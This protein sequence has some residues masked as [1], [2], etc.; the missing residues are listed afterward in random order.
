MFSRYFIA[1]PI[2]ASVCAAFIVIAGGAA[3]FN[4][5]Q[6]QWPNIQPREISVTTFYPGANAETLAN[7]V[8]APLEQQIGNVLGLMYTQSTSSGNGQL[9]IRATFDVNADIDVALLEV[10]SRAQKTLPR[11]PEEVRRQ[12]LSISKSAS[13]SLLIATLSSPDRRFDLASLNNYARLNI[14]D[15]LNRLPGVATVGLFTLRYYSLRIWLQP[16]KLARLGLSPLDVL[17]A[18]REQN[19]QYTAGR[20]G[21]EPLNEPVDFTFTVNVPG[22]MSTPE[23][24]E[25]IVLRTASSGAIVRLK[26]VARVELGSNRY[27]TTSKLNGEPALPLNITV[28]SGANAI[29]TAKIVRARL[30]ELSKTFPEGL[31]YSVNYDSTVHIR[32]AI[33]EVTLTLFEA[34]AL[35]F[36][37][38]FLF[39]G[40]WR[41]TLIP[42]LAVPVSI[43]GAFAV[44]YQMDF[45]I[46]IVTLFG[47]VFAIGIVV[48]DAIVVMENVQRIMQ[49]QGVDAR[50]ATEQTMREVTRPV[51]A[52]VLVLVAVFMP[53]AFMSG[54][55]GTIYRQF[56]VTIAGSVAISGIVALTLTPALCA[57][58]LR[59]SDAQRSGIAARFH[60]GFI[61]LTHGYARVVEFFVRQRLLSGFVFIAVLGAIGVFAYRIPVSLVP[62]E[63]RGLVYA[64][65][66]LP[67]AASMSRSQA[68]VDDLAAEL[69]KHPAV[70]DVIAFAGIDGISNSFLPGG[71]NMWIMLKPWNERRGK[72]MAPADVMESIEAFGRTGIHDAQVVAFEPSPIAGGSNTGNVDGFIQSRG[73]SDPKTL[74]KA[75]QA[76]VKA[77]KERKELVGVGTSY[78]ANVPQIRIDVDRDKAKS[79]GIDIGDLFTTL[80]SNFG[81]YYINDFMYAGRVWEVQMQ[82]D[83]PFRA[84]V[85]DLRNVFVSAQSG[86]LVPLTALI[87][88]EETTGPEVVERFNAFPA[89]RIYA[90]VASGHSSGAAHAAMEEIARQVLPPGYVLS[91]S[92]I[93]YQQRVIGTS[94]NLAFLVSVLMIFLILA[95]QYE[96]W[97]LPLAVILAVPFAVFGAFVA[98]WLRGLNNDIFF[99]IG[100]VTL[101]GLTAKNGI[102]MVEYAAQLEAKGK[103]LREAAFEAAQLRFRPIVMTSVAFMFGVLPLV[104]ASGAGANARH[105]IGTG[106]IGGMLAATFVATIFV[107]LFYMWIAGWRRKAG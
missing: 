12:G 27:D 25:Q 13:S 69:K 53:V 59:P 70:Q 8:A 4:I 62:R 100:L 93:S 67:D 50:T 95:A 78:R 64:S 83:A 47:M 102:L 23:E 10:N 85:E 98:I 14:V 107:P 3:M 55:T 52:I 65:P 34:L 20:I 17:R 88:V 106:V 74:A 60:R 9:S 101:V 103:S 82:A 19:S 89:A 11:L 48:D 71:G 73:A 16:D 90:R 75:V 96:R 76:F 91:W 29:E 86:A 40:S 31:V 81:A 72:G 24:F 38:V 45:T 22:R 63:D 18:V 7:T 32:N 99:Q 80:H 87:R 97:S 58:L 104:F 54:L 41:A 39:M 43:I 56:A 36:A 33:N 15:E 51:V 66:I 2:F 92:G 44:M 57:T 61:G 79:L 42:M 30:Q 49:T 35:V 94:T 68:V 46:N 6:T 5:A 26:D 21:E 105:S 84:R 77:A 37:V 1:R 28:Q